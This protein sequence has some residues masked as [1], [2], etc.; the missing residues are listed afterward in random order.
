MK[1]RSGLATILGEG[2]IIR[3]P[4]EAEVENCVV[5]EEVLHQKVDGEYPVAKMMAEIETLIDIA[6]REKRR[7]PKVI[8]R[9]NI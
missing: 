6:K 2:L 4:L 9:G 1:R 8:G 7:K 5:I 3:D